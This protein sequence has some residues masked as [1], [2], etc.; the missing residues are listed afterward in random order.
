MEYLAADVT[1]SKVLTVKAR[2]LRAVALVELGYINEAFLV[3]RRILL[4]KDLPEHGLPNS[5]YS[6]K[7]HGKNFHFDADSGYFNDLPPTDEKNAAA[8]KLMLDPISEDL[9]ANL[10]KFLSPYLVEMLKFVRVLLCVRTNLTE[11]PEGAP[12]S[13]A[14]ALKTAEDSL[15]AILRKLQYQEEVAHLQT[16]LELAKKREVDPDQEAIDKLTEQLE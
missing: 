4:L 9:E 7:L 6:Q 1:R 11:N 13:R 5:D 10:Q 8:V 15:R 2:L 12:E 16:A 14:T 3:Y